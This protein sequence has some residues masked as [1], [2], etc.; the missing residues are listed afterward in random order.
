MDTTT[1]KFHKR[2]F[3]SQNST[4]LD[5][6]IDKNGNLATHPYEIVNI[7][8]STQQQS[9]HMHAPLCLD[10]KDH[11]TNCTCVIRQYP[12]Q[13]IDGFTLEKWTSP[14][15]Q[16]APLTC[17]ACDTRLRNLPKR[18]TPGLDGTPNN[19]LKALSTTSTTCYS[20]FS[21]NATNKRSYPKPRNHP[22]W[23]NSHKHST[24]QA[25]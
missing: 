15:S 6:L 12:W 7:V 3:N 14:N 8:Y 20:Y 4:T 13:I 25:T 17:I 9:F 21:N 1:K 16:L 18:K 10:P 2:I 19:I 23:I 24:T 11:H 5:C 22:K